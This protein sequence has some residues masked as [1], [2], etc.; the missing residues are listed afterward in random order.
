MYAIFRVIK[1]LEK[2]R[3]HYYIERT[4]PDTIRLNATLVGQRVEIDIFEDGHIEISRFF[5]SEAVEG[6]EELLI[7]ILEEE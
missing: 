1:L 4:R 7:E 2:K 6:E 3:I 5:G